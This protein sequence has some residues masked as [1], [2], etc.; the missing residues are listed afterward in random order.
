M[1]R[2]ASLWTGRPRRLPSSASISFSARLS[3]PR[4]QL[5]P[6]PSRIASFRSRTSRTPPQFLV[7]GTQCRHLPQLLHLVRTCGQHLLVLPHR[8]PLLYPC[9]QT[10]CLVC[11]RRNPLCALDI[12]RVSRER[13]PGR[14][15]YPAR[16]HSHHCNSGCNIS[17]VSS[18]SWTNLSDHR[19]GAYQLSLLLQ[20]PIAQRA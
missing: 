16:S 18:V 13:L 20:L 17:S 5:R 9:H 4:L 7:S 3:H 15:V 8:S 19:P 11:C 2:S 1:A 12:A 14:P 6:S 10:S